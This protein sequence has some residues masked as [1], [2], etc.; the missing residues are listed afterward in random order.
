[1]KVNLKKIGLFILFLA[2]YFLPVLFFKTDKVF[3]LNLKKTFFAPKPIIFSIC[4]IILYIILAYFLVL[5]LKKENREALVI[6]AINYIIAFFFN[7]F[8]FVK[9]NLFLAF[10]D[11]FLCFCS[12][13]L[14]FLY[15]IKKDRY[16]AFILTPYLLWTGF[17][18][19]L[20]CTIYFLN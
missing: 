11:T 9:Q 1:M 13:L 4:W 20:M 10:C 7:F 5:I 14:V 16:Q 18:S 15:F 12:G 17:A 8:F 2:L 19:I 6:M 3:Y